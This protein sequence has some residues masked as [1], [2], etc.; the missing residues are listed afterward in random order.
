MTPS[1]RRPEF[2]TLSRET[3]WLGQAFG[4]KFVSGDKFYKRSDHYNFA[5]KKIPIMFFS[6]DEHPDYHMT[7]DTADKLD[8]DKLQKLGRLAFLVGYRTANR[9][10][11][12]KRLGR[13]KGWIDQQ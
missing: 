4:M 11:R 7:T 13:Q 9:T 1:Y 8:Y 2:S 10:G 6:D 5:K 3:A 12:P